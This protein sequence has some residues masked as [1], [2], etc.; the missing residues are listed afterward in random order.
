MSIE[1][2]DLVEMLKGTSYGALPQ[3]AKHIE[4]VIDTIWR[5][6]IVAS[7]DSERSTFLRDVVDKHID[8]LDPERV[9]RIKELD[10]Y[11]VAVPVADAIARID[12]QRQQIIVFD[13]L[14]QLIGAYGDLMAA[15]T[16]LSLVRPSRTVSI[17]GISTPELDAYTEAGFA[18]LAHC[19]ETGVLA[20]EFRRILGPQAR[21]RVDVAHAGAVLFVLAHEAGHLHLGHLNADCAFTSE[22]AYAALAVQESLSP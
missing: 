9:S 20:V 22:R 18:I 10:F 12:A 16:L 8:Y 21:Q 5:G 11:G 13:G 1:S 3:E 6:N 7:I 15:I 2:R 4:T 14:L 19:V 17:N